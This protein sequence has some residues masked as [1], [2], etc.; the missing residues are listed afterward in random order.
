MAKFTKNRHPKF[1]PDLTDYRIYV[2]LLAEKLNE[3]ALFKMSMTDVVKIL[4][5]QKMEEVL[6]DVVVNKKRNIYQTL[7]F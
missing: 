1:R 6:P 2:E 4:I 7:K 5:E 3:G